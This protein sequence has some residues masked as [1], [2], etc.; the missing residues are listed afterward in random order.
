M[1]SGRNTPTERVV[2]LILL[3]LAFTVRILPLTWGHPDPAFARSFHDKGMI[4]EQTPLHPDEYF[5]AAVPF[6]KVLEPQSNFTFYENPSFL[7]NVSYVVARFSGVGQGLDPRDRAG[8]NERY[9][10]PFSLYMLT[11]TLSALGGVLAVVSLGVLLV[12]LW[13]IWQR[14]SV[15]G[16]VG[17]LPEGARPVAVIYRLPRLGNEHP[18]FTVDYFHSPTIHLFCLNAVACNATIPTRLGN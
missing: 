2:A 4:H 3:A 8:L 18:A 10:A 15:R 7:V 16:A 17:V 5:F 12:G 1:Q 6:R 14:R 9:Y 11:R 13:L